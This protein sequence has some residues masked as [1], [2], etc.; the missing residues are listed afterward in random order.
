MAEAGGLG[1]TDVERITASLD[2]LET[3]FRPLVEMIPHDADPAVV[4]R[5]TEE[6]Q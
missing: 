6:P 3:A 4:F 2:S 1:I 5:A